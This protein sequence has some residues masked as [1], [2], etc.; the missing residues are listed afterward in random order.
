M[1]RVPKV[2]FKKPYQKPGVKVYGN[3]EGLTANV[4]NTANPDGGGGAMSK[5]H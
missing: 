1:H 3:I 2:D 5:T 4:G